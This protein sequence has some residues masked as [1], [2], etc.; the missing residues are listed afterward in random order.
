[1]VHD[2]KKMWGYDD[3][4]ENLTYSDWHSV[5]VPEDKEVFSKN[6]RIKD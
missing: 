5:I 6:R 4:K 1:M 3:Q 2:I